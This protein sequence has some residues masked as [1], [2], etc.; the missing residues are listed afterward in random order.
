MQNFQPRNYRIDNVEL[1]WAKLSKPVSPFG[2]PQYEL[3]IATTDAATAESWK[4]NHLPV[5]PEIDKDT[6]KP[7]GKFTVSLKRKANKADG[8][9]NGAPRVVDATAQPMDSSKI[10]N[11]SRGNVIIYQM[12]Y[13]N[14][15]RE[16][17]SNSLTAV[18][19]SDLEVYTGSA[20]FE[21]ITDLAADASFAATAN[22]PATNSATPD[23]F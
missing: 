6:K 10:G 21:P 3:Q 20:D 16:G 17:I 18:Q 11:G 2:V 19:V 1:N 7:T 12:Y 15:G 9:D 4:A 8:S 13:K 23:P 22:A 5:K 14:A